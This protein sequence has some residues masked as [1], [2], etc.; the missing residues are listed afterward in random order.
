MR[1]SVAEC[2]IYQ[3][4]LCSV[5]AF[6]END[7]AST[8]KKPS[9]GLVICDECEAIWFQPDVRGVHVYA[10]SES[11]HCPITGDPLYDEQTSRWANPDDVL[12]LGWADK[13]DHSLT[14]DPNSDA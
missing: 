9:H 2:P 5:R 8:S 1:Y 10:D 4:G 14:H 7:I 13:I 12:A 6:F 3:A 11:P